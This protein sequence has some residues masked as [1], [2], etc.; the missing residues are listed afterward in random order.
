MPHMVSKA[1]SNKIE[2]AQNNCIRFC[3]N[4]NNQAHLRKNEFKDIDWIPV[5]E[6]LNQPC[7]TPI[8]FLNNTAP[9][10]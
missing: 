6:K 9:H 2:C 7:M 5:S 8:S 4:L 10:I 1:L 3:L